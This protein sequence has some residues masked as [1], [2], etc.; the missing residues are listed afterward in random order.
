MPSIVRVAF[1]SVIS[2]PTQV[3]WRSITIKFRQPLSID[4]A[5]VSP[6]AS[7]LL[8]N[9]GFPIQGDRRFWHTSVLCLDY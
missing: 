2:G 8:A 5:A 1:F 6:I 9:S 7:D 4:L 3:T